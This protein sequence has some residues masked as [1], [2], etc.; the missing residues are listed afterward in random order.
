[1]HRQKVLQSMLPG[2]AWLVDVY[3]LVLQLVTVDLLRI[4][5]VHSA[6]SHMRGLH[7]YRASSDS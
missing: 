5:R 6:N 2:Y 4:I 7:G 3:N 1:M